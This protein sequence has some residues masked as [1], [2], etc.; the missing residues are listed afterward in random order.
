[1]SA[2][3]H[4]LGDRLV[5][6]PVLSAGADVCL[7]CQQCALAHQPAT[8]SSLW[9]SPIASSLAA[10]QLVYALFARAV[11][12]VTDDTP[13][14]SV[15]DGQVLGTRLYR[16]N[17]HPLCRRHGVVRR[18]V[19]LPR[20]PL[21]ERAAGVLR[22]DVPSAVDAP[23]VVAVQDE[24]TALIGGWTSD[25]AGPLL[26]AG[27]GDL[28]QLPL[29]ASECSV[30]GPCREH[31]GEHG[32]VCHALSTR[33]ARN[34][35]VLCAL[36]WLAG[37]LA[38]ASGAARGPAYG[39]GWSAEEAAYRALVQLT[40]G[41]DD[42]D[43]PG[44]TVEVALDGDVAR[45]LDRLLADHAPGPVQQRVRLAPTGLYVADVRASNDVGGR[46]AGATS[47][48]AIL[49]ARLD[50]AHRIVNAGA[51]GDARPALLTTGLTSWRSALADARARA[52]TLRPATF[53][54]LD[55]LLPFARRGLHVVVVET[56]HA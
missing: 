39:V 44:D 5:V 45:F 36:E 33:E 14:L 9:P 11:G 22:P 2:A 46:G 50:L 15:I 19:A 55:G 8:A 26:R 21:G 17:P 16:L 29:A 3:I 34:Q 1:L 43:E 27:E 53:A 6:S 24:I 28:A 51:S 20:V 4:G 7:E 54:Y 12:V 23:E 31:E 49:N 52:H 25:V 18:G 35:A 47:D 13:R 38:A 41:A 40:L 42:A 37:E 10:H 56:S 30:R 48:N 32:V